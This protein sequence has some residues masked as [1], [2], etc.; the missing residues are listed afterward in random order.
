[1]KI[2]FDKTMLIYKGR[3]IDV[4]VKAEGHVFAE[5]RG[6]ESK[7]DV[8]NFK[9]VIYGKSGKDITKRFQRLFDFEFKQ[10]EKECEDKLIHSYDEFEFEG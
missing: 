3:W 4:S 2:V 9:M 5:G 7:T 10:L 1:M 6:G 8:D